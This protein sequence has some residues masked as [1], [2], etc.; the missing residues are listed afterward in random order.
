ML[1]FHLDQSTKKL[2]LNRE[3][4]NYLV[5]TYFNIHVTLPFAILHLNDD[6]KLRQIIFFKFV[7]YI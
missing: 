1:L 3:H 7:H 6:R 4:E 5:L 2:R